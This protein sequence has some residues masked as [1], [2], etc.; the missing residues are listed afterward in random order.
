MEINAKL[1]RAEYPRPQMV[2]DSYLCLNGT[3]QFDIDHAKTGRERGLI[4]AG[5][6]PMEITVPFCPESKLSGVEYKDFMLSVWYKRTVAL[7]KT[8]KRILLHIDACDYA[9]E[10]WVNGKSCGVHFGGS[11]PIVHD[12]T[13]F[14]VDGDNLIT[15][16]AEDDTR[17]GCQPCGKQSKIFHSHGC[18]YTR[19][20]GIWQTVWI[21]EVPET[22]IT[23]FKLTPNAKAGELLCEVLCENA[24]GM[25]LSCASSFEGKDTG[26][27]EAVVVGKTARFILKLT[28][29]HLWEVGNGRLYDLIFTLGEDKVGSYFG[30]RDI[31]Y[32]GKKM[33]LNGKPVFQRLVLDQGFYPDGIWTAPTAD[34]LEADIRRSLAMG[35]NGA[36]LHQKVFEP[37]FLYYCDK[38]GYIVWGEH[39]NWGLDLSRPT[40]WAGFLPEWLSILERDYNHPA[41]IGWCP[42][43]ETQ[44]NQDHRFVTM[45]YDMTKA[46]DPSRMFIDC[47]GWHHVKT[48]VEDCHNYDQNPESFK[49]NFAPLA[50]GKRPLAKDYVGVQ[51]TEKLSFVSEYGGIGWTVGEGAWGYGNAPKTE[52]EFLARLKGLTD[53][54]LD[55]PGISAYCYTQLTDIEQEQNGLYTYGR[56]PK[57][58][59]EQIHPILSRKAV[60]EE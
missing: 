52:E 10:V 55:N 53:A 50:E 1:P 5:T 15:V 28:E 57:F 44:G 13:D 49:N 7:K 17:S 42:L 27:A 51:P 2:R 23:S 4:E 48:E 6:L 31:V 43:N 12:I 34:E 41:I 36:R 30:L 14:A 25:T 21:E 47:S 3:W 54:M 19:T 16:C 59:P 45:L 22:Y 33:L 56:T 35:F 20:T 29:K 24:D 46:F 26:K 8:G 58:P 37:R 40:A 32:D 11:S 18:D 38:L 9:A 39:G 60:I